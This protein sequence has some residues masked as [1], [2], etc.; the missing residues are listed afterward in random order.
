MFFKIQIF[1]AAFSPVGFCNQ[2]PRANSG[3]G[4][5]AVAWLE[6]FFC[7]RIDGRIRLT[8]AAFVGQN[9]EMAKAHL[10]SWVLSF[11]TMFSV[12]FTFAAA[13]DR[14]TPY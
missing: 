8:S 13:G 12:S 14:V 5:S 9:G 2:V 1:A 3:N 6:F 10:S 4:P 11:L 7:W